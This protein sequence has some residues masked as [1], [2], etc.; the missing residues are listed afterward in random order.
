[1][2]PKGGNL[3]SIFLILETTGIEQRMCIIS[4]F[5]F[6]FS[7]ISLF[8]PRFSFL[9]SHFF[10]QFAGLISDSLISESS[11][12]ISPSFFISHSSILILMIFLISQVSVF[13]SHASFLI[14]H[15]SLLNPYFLSSSSSS[16]SS[17]DAFVHFSNCSKRLFFVQHGV[18]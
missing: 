9:N 14:A 8:I 15:S 3:H 18:A 5:S 13:I 7:H 16:S 10:S 11:F 4:H 12:I 1:M 2:P 6:L 17:S